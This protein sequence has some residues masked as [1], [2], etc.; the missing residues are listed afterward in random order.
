MVALASR[1]QDRAIQFFAEQ[2]KLESF[3]AQLEETKSL[4]EKESNI[5]RFIRRG[6]LET[7]RSRHSVEL[8]LHDFTDRK[9]GYVQSLEQLRGETEKIQKETQIVEA[10]LCL[11]Y[12]SDAADE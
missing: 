6:L 1:I 3:T 5:N 4:E 9:T 2:Q 7:T 11:L 10:K 12:T 8:E